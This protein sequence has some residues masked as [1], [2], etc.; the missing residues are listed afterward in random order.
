MRKRERDQIIRIVPDETD[1]VRKLL[2]LEKKSDWR[3]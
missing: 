3:R 1:M 2:P